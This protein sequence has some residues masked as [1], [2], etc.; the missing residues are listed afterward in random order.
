[1]EIMPTEAAIIFNSRIFKVKTAH[2][3]KKIS[4]RVKGFDNK[5]SAVLLYSSFS[6]ILEART[7]EKMLPSTI[8]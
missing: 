7:M 4:P 3:V 8:I 1:M 6:K 5:N 2:L